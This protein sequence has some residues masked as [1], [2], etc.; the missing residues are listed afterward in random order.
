MPGHQKHNG[1]QVIQHAKKKGPQTGQHIHWW[2]NIASGYYNCFMEQ[3]R[4]NPEKDKGKIV[5]IIF[6]YPIKVQLG[7]ENITMETIVCSLLLFPA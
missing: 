6:F 3:N 4:D 7:I 2:A 5:I 1:V